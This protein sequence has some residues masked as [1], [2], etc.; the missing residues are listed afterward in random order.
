MTLRI[1]TNEDG[2]KKVT[3]NIATLF[4]DVCGTS[5]EINLNTVATY[6]DQMATHVGIRLS[7]SDLE[8]S[9]GSITCWPLE[10]G[11]EDAQAL[12]SAKTA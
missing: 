7:C 10:N 9:C 12:A 8:G 6:V 1:E 4:C 3:G 2:S 11:T 5:K